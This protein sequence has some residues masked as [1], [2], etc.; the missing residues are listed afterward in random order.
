MTNL[1][2]SVF[3]PG[4]TPTLLVAT[5]VTFGAL[6]L[7]LLT[8]LVATYSIHFAI[9]SLLCGGLWY[10]INWFAVELQ[11]AQRTEV[12]AEKLR[13]KKNAVA[14]EKKWG[15][16]DADDEGEDTEVEMDGVKN[17]RMSASEVSLDEG[18]RDEAAATAK[19][20][21]MGGGDKAAQA[22]EAQTTAVKVDGG[23]AAD[24]QSRQRRLEESKSETGT[25]SEWEKVDER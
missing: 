22:G 21:V 11:N 10:S 13:Q 7:L 19:V 1:W 24:A 23:V 6:Q 4:T 17:V 14:E 25:D 9:L 3:T 8:L 12:E 18:K 15:G 5:N 16:G 20:V 2:E